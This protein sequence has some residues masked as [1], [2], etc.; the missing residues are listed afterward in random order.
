MFKIHHFSAA[1]KL[2]FFTS[3]L[4]EELLNILLHPKPCESQLLLLTSF[5][6][7]QC[8]DECKSCPEA[9]IP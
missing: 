5:A 6:P 4:L 7:V 1:A 3:I 9:M 2:I 8:G